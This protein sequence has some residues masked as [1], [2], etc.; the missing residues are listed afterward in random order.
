MSTD[1]R[2]RILHN[3]SRVIGEWGTG[4]SGPVEADYGFGMDEH[5][6]RRRRGGRRILCASVEYLCECGCAGSFRHVLALL[7]HL[8]ERGR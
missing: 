2:R 7:D 1:E 4:E 8:E 5:V 3:E 6:I